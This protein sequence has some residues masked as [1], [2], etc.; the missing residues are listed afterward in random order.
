MFYRSQKS[1]KWTSTIVSKIQTQFYR[2]PSTFGQQ[3][4]KGKKLS[5]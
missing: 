3:T 5:K 4:E 1:K 2:L